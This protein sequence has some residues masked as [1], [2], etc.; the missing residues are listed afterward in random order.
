MRAL[1]RRL[2]V[3]LAMS[4]G[5]A[6]LSYTL[7]AP[8]QTPPAPPAG[9]SKAAECIGAL[10]RAQVSRAARKLLEARASYVACSNEACPDMV[11]DDCSKG[12]REVDEALPT[13]V[14]SASAEGRDATDATVILDGERLAQGLD[15]RAISVDPGP[16]LTRFE[17]PGNAP[18]EVKIVAREGEKNRLVNGEFV[19][20]HAAKPVTKAEG[21]RIPVVPLAFAATGAIALGTALVV[22]LSMTSRAD[23]LGRTCAPTCSASDR[24]ALSDRLVLRNVALGI[25]LGSL[26]VAAVTY[27]VGLRR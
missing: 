16:H 26:A 13:L 2:S 24:D 3:R 5:M 10:D 27:V 19:L 9:Q 7:S 21:Q 17:R 23:D 1:N 8:A 15:G 14:L 20:P 12:L 22:H 6:A 18:V 4:A 11:R 25:G